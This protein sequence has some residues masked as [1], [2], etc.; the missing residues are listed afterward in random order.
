MGGQA[1]QARHARQQALRVGG[2][3]HQAG[4]D[5]DQQQAGG[6]KDQQGIARRA[7]RQVAFGGGGQHRRETNH[8]RVH[9][10]VRHVRIGAQQGG[11]RHGAQPESQ[12]GNQ[13]CGG[14]LRGLV[15]AYQMRDQ[16]FAGQ[17]E[18]QQ[19]SQGL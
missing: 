10:V 17:R 3:Q 16:A 18:Q 4:L 1:S 9:I 19:R 11:R 12:K 14:R 13:Q 7:K 6:D 2:V 5:G 15:A 8:Q